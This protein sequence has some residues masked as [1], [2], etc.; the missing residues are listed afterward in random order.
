MSEQDEILNEFV[1][2]KNPGPIIPDDEV[3][4]QDLTPR[5]RRR[6]GLDLKI[7]SNENREAGYETSDESGNSFYIFVLGA[8]VL[9]HD[10]RLARYDTIVGIHWNDLKG[11]PH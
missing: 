11:V 3:K 1:G 5:K 2:E 8:M 10:F 7:G 9:G 6:S 4:K